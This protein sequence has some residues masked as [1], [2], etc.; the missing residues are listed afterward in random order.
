M[1]NLKNQRKVF[2]IENLKWELL[3]DESENQSGN[4]YWFNLS[5]NHSSGEGSY[6]Y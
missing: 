4:I 3:D 6:L 1:N 5:Y 2:N